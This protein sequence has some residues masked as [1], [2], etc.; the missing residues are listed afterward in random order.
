MKTPNRF[1]SIFTKERKRTAGRIAVVAVLV[2]LTAMLWGCNLKPTALIVSPAAG[3]IE[4]AR[5]E[6]VVFEGIGIGGRP[7]GDEYGYF[8]DLD[9]NAADSSESTTSKANSDS[10]TS[11]ND[12]T[13]STTTTTNSVTVTF[14]YLGTY[15]I[16]FTV[17]DQNGEQDTASVEVTVV[18][19][20][21]REALD[22]QILNPVVNTIDVA[23]GATVQ[24]KGGGTGGVPFSDDTQAY[25]YFWDVLNLS[26]VELADGD[27][28]D[29]AT[30]T[31]NDQSTAL[32]FNKSG[33]YPITLTVQDSR[34]VTDTATVTVNVGSSASSSSTLSAAI[35][36]PVLDN[37][38]VQRNATTGNVAVSFV[39]QADGGSG[40]YYYFWDVLKYNEITTDGN[41][42]GI[43]EKFTFTG[44]GKSPFT[45]QFIVKDS[46]GATATDTV[47]VTV[48]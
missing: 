7:I 8:W 14:S 33:S 44:N 29:T 32:K 38:E 6:T 39:G 11:D 15:T 17:T 42:N 28:S 19:E 37:L 46:E 20:T 34:G 23:V 22:A 45:I 3:S 5:G 36:T 25:Y 40:A 4:I 18:E 35:V 12:T 41:P 31:E 30:D 27:D 26:G 16:S 24:F 1:R 47:T 2:F 48:K 10:D 43:E 13:T 21:A 9:G